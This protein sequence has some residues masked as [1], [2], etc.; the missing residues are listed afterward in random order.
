VTL[1]KTEEAVM[2]R[3]MAADR[4]IPAHNIMGPRLSSSVVRASSGRKYVHK[5]RR[6]GVRIRMSAEGYYLPDRYSPPLPSPIVYV[7]AQPLFAILDRCYQAMAEARALNARQPVEPITGDARWVAARAAKGTS[8]P[9][10]LEP[11]ARLEA[12]EVSR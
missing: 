11:M 7:E 9:P 5:L 10:Y 3:L 2:D 8:E 4:P 12:M 6:K 1:T